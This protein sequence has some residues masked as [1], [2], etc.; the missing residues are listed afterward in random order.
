[1]YKKLA[2]R[3]NFN[4]MLPKDTQECQKMLAATNLQQSAVDDHFE[5]A[6][7]EDKPVLYADNL[8]HEAAIEWLIETNQV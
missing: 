4:S 1:M 7:P 5:L 8:F 2:K 3:N 6:C